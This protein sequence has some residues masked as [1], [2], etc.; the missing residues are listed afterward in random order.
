MATVAS[1]LPV[2]VPVSPW[3]PEFPT[4]WEYGSSSCDHT[5]NIAVGHSPPSPVRYPARRPSKIL[6]KNV[7][8]VHDVNLRRFYSER[9]SVLFVT[10]S[11]NPQAVRENKNSSVPAPPL[12]LVILSPPRASWFL[13]CA[14][15]VPHLDKTEDQ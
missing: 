8:D 9:F 11:Q 15:F 2:E 3:P 14:I 1:G 6:W 7:I 5:E 10:V 13:L 12:S 4:V